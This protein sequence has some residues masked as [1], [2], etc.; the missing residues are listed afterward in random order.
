M[1][2]PCTM[3]SSSTRP[4]TNA[5]RDQRLV[6]PTRQKDGI[7]AAEAE[8]GPQAVGDSACGGQVHV[9]SWRSV[10][11]TLQTLHPVLVLLPQAATA[12]T[13]NRPLHFHLQ[14]WVRHLPVPRL[15]ATGETSCVSLLCFTFACD[16]SFPLFS[17]LFLAHNDD[18]TIRSSTTNGLSV[19]LAA[20][21]QSI[22][23]SLETSIQICSKTRQIQDG[24]HRRRQGPRP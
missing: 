16:S 20:A 3:D 18:D 12:L 19:G 1:G 4:D 17:F 15:Q 23:P 9:R 14:P 24:V 6:P 10:S 5:T 8:H 11:Q 21:V 22:D 13:R 2:C 7:R